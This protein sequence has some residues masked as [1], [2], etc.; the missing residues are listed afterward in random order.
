MWEPL[1]GSLDELHER[2]VVGELFAPRG[3][4]GPTPDTS[5]GRFHD[6]TRGPQPTLGQPIPNLDVALGPPDDEVEGA[7]PRLVGGD[8]GVEA[9][10]FQGFD[11]LVS[12]GLVRSCSLI[13][14]GWDESRP[15]GVQ[16]A[17]ENVERFR[18]DPPQE[19]LTREKGVR[20]ALESRHRMRI[21]APPLEDDFDGLGFHQ[22]SFLL[23]LW[24][25]DGLGLLGLDLGGGLG[26]G[27]PLAALGG[28]FD[29]GL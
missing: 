24:R 15:G 28:R 25:R 11:G 14:R 5:S 9:R 19:L 29:F 16:S 18:G 3:S 4:C 10:G 6:S 23:C 27:R 13:R 2:V 1:E 7:P 20:F 8:N 22:R 12:L 26:L 17:P 21:H